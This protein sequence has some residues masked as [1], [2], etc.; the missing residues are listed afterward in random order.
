MI[1]V[2]VVVTG[3]GNKVNQ[4]SFGLGHSLPTFI[5]GYLKYGNTRKSLKPKIII[6]AI[7]V[8]Y[9]SSQFDKECNYLFTCD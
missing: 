2:I 4:S 3:G 9:L 7:F 8:M 5:M 6:C 1:I